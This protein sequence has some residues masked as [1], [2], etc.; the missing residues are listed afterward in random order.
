MVHTPTA[1]D[2]HIKKGH[3]LKKLGDYTSASEI[4]EVCR[5]LDLQDR[6]LN[7]IATK[8][9]LQA[10]NIDKAIETISMFTKV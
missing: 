8:R 1:L 10:D 2:M 3:L 7:N 6:Y 5:S 9:F 4:V